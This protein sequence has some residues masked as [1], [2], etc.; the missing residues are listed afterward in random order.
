MT[1]LTAFF[2]E[3]GQR[4][5]E[6]LRQPVQTFHQREIAQRRPEV[7]LIRARRGMDGTPAM[8]ITAVGV[9]TAAPRSRTTGRRRRRE[10]PRRRCAR[11]VGGC[12]CEAHTT[13][14]SG[15]SGCAPEG[16]LMWR[17]L[18]RLCFRERCVPNLTVCDLCR[19]RLN[20]RHRKDR[21]RDPRRQD[22]AWRKA[23]RTAVPT[24][25]DALLVV[26][27]GATAIVF[28]VL[29]LDALIGG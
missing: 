26:A 15:V 1:P 21:A 13:S 9:W 4:I 16:G 25:T 2:D 11:P 6:R 10:C 7:L 23:L 29:A 3:Q 18:C 22:A 20:A 8:S 19:A 17:P 12:R 5:R 28:A 24:P 14:V 27:I